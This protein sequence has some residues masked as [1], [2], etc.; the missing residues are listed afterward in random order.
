MRNHIKFLFKT[1]FFFSL[2]ILS[3]TLF[4][5]GLASNTIA[6]YRVPENVQKEILAVLEQ[7]QKTSFKSIQLDSSLPLNEQKNKLNNAEILF[8]LHDLQI[9]EF[10]HSSPRVKSLPSAY[11]TGMPRSI[12][13]SVEKYQNVV[14]TVPV[15]FDYYMIAVDYPMYKRSK[16]PT[17][18]YWSDFIRTAKIQNNFISNPI[19]FA[20]AQDD[21]LINIFGM[22]TEAFLG[23][24]DYNE[25][26]QT[27]YTA[28]KEDIKSDSNSEIQNVEN[29]SKALEDLTGP[30]G[31]LNQTIVE[32]KSLISQ[33]LL[34][35]KCLTLDSYAAAELLQKELISMYFTNLSTHRTLPPE[36]N[37]VYA[38]IYCP[39]HQF[40]EERSFVAPEYC[41]MALSGS[42][43]TQRRIVA[44]SST[45]QTQLSTSTGLAPVQID[46]ETADEIANNVRY[47][48][49]ASNGALK[50]FTAALPSAFQRSFTSQYLRNLLV[51]FEL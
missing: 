10:A 35:P 25:A 13:K 24:A 40:N 41:A 46:C 23:S 9:S 18:D 6:F 4:S 36:I 19:A 47:W 30:G 21:D 43:V 51:S 45:Y 29:L 31:L 27:I 7:S 17:I 5:C 42:K 38:P 48:L 12:S 34:S 22:L 33:E 37:Q 44:V 14:K 2:M 39:A 15:L 50:P 1:L 28:A 8:A 49:T 3:A 20:G 26:L 32:I 11:L 16:V